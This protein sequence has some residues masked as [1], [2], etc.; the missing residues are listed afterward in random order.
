MGANRA[1][2]GP[3]GRPR[4][5]N[6]LLAFRREGTTLR[7]AGVYDK[8][9][10]V[11]FGEF[12][13]LGDLARTLGIRSLVHME[14]DFTP[15]PRP[16]PLV[17]PGL[18][19]VQPL[20]C[21]EAL[22]PG[23]AVGPRPEWILNVSNDA[24]FGA[25]SGPWQHLNIAS[26]R[27]IEQGLP[28]VRAT[29]TG[30]SAIIDAQGRLVPGLKLGLGAYGVIDAPLPRPAAPTPYSRWGDIPFAL[31]LVLSGGAWL[32]GRRRRPRAGPE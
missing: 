1:D 23:L 24:W 7:V 18:P 13:P 27:A 14:D 19:A 15:G 29:P 21:Y 10:L 17:A 4:Y 3:D 20:I 26:Y 16:R 32:A 2:R 22:F 5:F 25:T 8:H 31:L 30:V 6:T 28:I 11:P 9:R 12:L